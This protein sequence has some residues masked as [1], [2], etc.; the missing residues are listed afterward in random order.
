MLVGKLFAKIK[1]PSILGWLIIG[2]LFGP[3]AL[4]LVSRPILD[5]VWYKTAIMWMQCAFGLMLG[6]ELVWKELRNCG[7]ALII[8]TLTQ[9]LGTFCFVTFVFAIVFP[10]ADVP[11]HL[12]F[13]FGAI[14]LAT[15]PAPA[16]SIVNEFHA[17]GPV[18]NTL[19][20]MAVMYWMILQQ[21]LSFSQSIPLL[22]V[23]YR[24]VPFHCQ[25]FL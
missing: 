14:S 17:N 18:T 24:V 20:P 3:H 5:A 4:G 8:T 21:S 12:A 25:R 22:P 23:P 19:L 15:A 2:M 10:L 16:L 1:L 13:I 7:K 6:T 11:I 9:S